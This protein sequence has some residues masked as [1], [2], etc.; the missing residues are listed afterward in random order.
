MEEKK[1]EKSRNPRNNSNLDWSNYDFE[2]ILQRVG[3]A[4]EIPEVEVDLEG[5]NPEK[6]KID[7][8]IPYKKKMRGTAA[9]Q[10]YNNSDYTYQQAKDYIEKHGYKVKTMVVEDG[11][12]GCVV[13]AEKKSSTVSGKRID[14]NEIF[15]KKTSAK[16][17][18]INMTTDSK[19]LL[20]KMCEE[21]PWGVKGVAEAEVIGRAIEM[22][23]KA[24][25][26]IP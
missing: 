8:W 12:E 18:S 22:Y 24:N 10:C 11:Y 5:C 26:F 7:K 13:R 4:S 15:G 20:N 9:M 21:Y 19:A 14:L 6:G 3:T 2:E 1:F 23:A 17:I 16:K 25:G